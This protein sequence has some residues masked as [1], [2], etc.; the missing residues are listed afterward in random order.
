ME[1][2]LKHWELVALSVG[3]SGGGGWLGY[4]LAYKTRKIDVQTKAFEMQSQMIDA[5]KKDFEDR[6][7]CLEQYIDKLKKLIEDC[8]EQKNQILD[9]K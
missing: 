7:S 3:T 5:I 6:I 4:I 2:L 8:E 1:I 9:D